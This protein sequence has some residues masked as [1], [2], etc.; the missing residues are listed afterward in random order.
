MPF[1]VTFD[2]SEFATRYPEFAA[3]SPSLLAAKWDEADL[4]FTNDLTRIT[5]VGRLRILFDMLTAH[6]AFIGGALE[7]D[8]KPRPVGRLSN[9][10][11]GTVSAAFDYNAD[12]GSESW[13]LQTQYGAA[14][15]RATAW[16][17]LSN[18]VFSALVIL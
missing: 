4:Y 17:R 10:S 1:A 6:I 7:A 14:F 5:D 18:P 11:E 2:F 15:W 13:F 16:I 8:G 3:V 12:A 9:A